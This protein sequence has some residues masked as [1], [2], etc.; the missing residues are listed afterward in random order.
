MKMGHGVCGSQTEKGTIETVHRRGGVAARR[1]REGEQV[2][3]SLQ[4]GFDICLSQLHMQKSNTMWRKQRMRHFFY[5]LCVCVC[6][7]IVP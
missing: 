7:S 6:K 2:M 4:P 1:N 5:F 3:K